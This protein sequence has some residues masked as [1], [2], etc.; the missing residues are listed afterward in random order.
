MGARDRPGA[1]NPL[2]VH[3][4][5]RVLV[6]RPA[7]PV[8]AERPAQVPRVRMACPV[9]RRPGLVL[10][11]ARPVAVL[12][13]VVARRPVELALVALL[14]VAELRLALRADL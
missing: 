10:E 1:V 4:A 11:R 7:S 5:R 3:R 9:A 2:R 8:A 14:R 12:L 13:L 6:V